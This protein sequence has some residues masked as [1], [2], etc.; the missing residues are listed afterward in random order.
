MKNILNLIK[1]ELETCY[2]TLLNSGFTSTQINSIKAQINSVIT[3]FCLNEP[4]NN[5]EEFKSALLTSVSEVVDKLVQQG[6][7]PPIF[8]SSNVDGGDEHNHAM[9]EKYYGYW[10]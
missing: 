6:I 8:K 4:P 9:F 5:P 3:A 1:N 10:K 7:E 2:N